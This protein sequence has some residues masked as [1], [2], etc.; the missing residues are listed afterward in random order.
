[1]TITQDVLEDVDQ[2]E[3]QPAPTEFEAGGQATMDNLHEVNL[4]D[5][6]ENKPT[7][8]SANLKEEEARQYISFLR[9]YHDIFAWN[10]SEMPAW[11]MDIIGPF[12]PPSSTGYRY[13]LAATDYFSKWAE[14]VALKD[15]KS[16]VVSEFIRTH[17]IY[18]FGIPESIIMDNG[19]PFR[20]DALNKLFA[21]YKIK[22]NHSSRYHAPANGLAEAFNKTLCK[23]LKKMVDKNKKAWHE[24]LQEALWTYRTSYRT[25]TQATPYSL[26]FGGEAV[27]P[28]EVQIPSLRVAIQESL[29]EDESARVRL[30][31]LETLD[32]RRLYAQQNLEIYQQRMANAFN[33]RVR[34]RSFKKGDLVLMVRTPIVVSRR[35]KGKLEPK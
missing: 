25:P 16:T 20:S 28:L 12:V 13:I 32:E 7:F 21:K 19:Q 6:G 11:G 26:V 9:E 8:I 23:I 27:L 14:A 3:A 18:R 30:A 22:N 4:C 15:I 29:T 34:L 35:T 17:I 33:K 31:E 5:Q 10:Y 2:D 24:K 1:M